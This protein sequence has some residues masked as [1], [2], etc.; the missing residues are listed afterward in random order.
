MPEQES[1]MPKFESMEQIVTRLDAVH[2]VAVYQPTDFPVVNLLGEQ[3]K[4]PLTVALDIGIEN[5][6]IVVTFALWMYT[7]FTDERDNIV[8]EILLSPCLYRCLLVDSEVNRYR[9]LNDSFHPQYASQ[10][11][12]H[13][14]SNFCQPIDR[15]GEILK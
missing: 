7:R 1:Y 2:H 14:I 15:N 6:Y 13:Y 8:D 12:P 10:L 5:K 9:V 11:V 3:D 4:M